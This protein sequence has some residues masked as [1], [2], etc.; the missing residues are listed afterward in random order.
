MRHRLPHALAV[1]GAAAI[2]AA[3]AS[4]ADLPFSNADPQPQPEGP[5]T[6]TGGESQQ[7]DA[8]ER[9][10]EPR[11]RARTVRLSNETTSSKWAYVERST[12]ARRSPSTRSHSVKR[13][14]TYTSDGT[15][16]LVLTLRERRLSNGST[17]VL[18]RLPMRPNGRTGWVRRT[19]LGGYHAVRTALKIRRK[20]FRATLYRG[21][22]KVWSAP[23]GIGKSK[24]PTPRGRFYVRERLVPH[25]KNGIYGI[26][27]FGT[28]A[29]SA[30]LTDWPGGG[31]IGIHG[32]NQP[33][34]IPGRISH[35]CVRV[36]N[37]KIRRLKR[38]MP[39][40]TP[41]RIT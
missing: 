27:A 28:S 12:S 33:R 26:F 31:V 37:S 6:A 29:Y 16:E 36:R 3:P 24:W 19:D 40:G 5:P 35:G 38:L 1:L 17:W 11:A 18:V 4:A 7:N 39:L 20:S 25:E 41:I 14:T 10:P 22:R 9:P 2:A 34:L 30:V 13:L 21:G 8:K 23:V 15:P 32:T